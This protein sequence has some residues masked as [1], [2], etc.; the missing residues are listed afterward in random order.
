MLAFSSLLP[1]DYAQPFWIDGRVGNN[2]FS[3]ERRGPSPRLRVPSLIDGSLTDVAP[4]DHVVFEDIDEHGRLQSCTGLANLIRTT[5]AGVPTVVVDNHNHA[6]YFWFEALAAGRLEPGATLVH[7]D[8]HRDTRTPERP[9]TAAATLTDVFRY[10]N[11]HLNV[12]NYIVPAMRAGLI[13]ETLFV[14]GGDSLDDRRFVGRPN[15]I[16]N[17]DLD[18]F[19]PG[20]S[21]IDFDRARRFIDAHLPGTSLVTVATSPFFIEQTSAIAVLRRL[22]DT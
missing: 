9:F 3:Y 13:G 15:T 19:A 4:G 8:Q 12:G 18:F 22:A 14:T 21:Y 6:F 2:A 20:M 1:G 5:W 7:V 10:T 11:F 16:L 17:I